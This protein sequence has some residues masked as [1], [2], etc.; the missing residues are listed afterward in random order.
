[1]KKF[2]LALKKFWLYF[3]LIAATIIGYLAFFKKGSVDFK[4]R[5]TKF[6]GGDKPKA[7]PPR[8]KE[9]DWAGQVKKD[10]A[11]VAK[12]QDKLSRADLIKKANSKYN[13]KK[14][15]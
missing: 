13:S 8:P 7:L 10:L 1:M 14:G 2:Q 5:P 9:T 12:E 6:P 3:A 4:D 11:S 15:K